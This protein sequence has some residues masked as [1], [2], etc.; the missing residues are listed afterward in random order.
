[1]IEGKWKLDC[2]G[3]DSQE[4]AEALVS[5]MIASYRDTTSGNKNKSVTRGEI[6]I[7]SEFIL[8]SEGKMLTKTEK[9]M[10]QVREVLLLVEGAFRGYISHGSISL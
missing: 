8:Y 10:V 6:C 9:L 1:M 3:A 7:I 4:A 2:Y 5:R